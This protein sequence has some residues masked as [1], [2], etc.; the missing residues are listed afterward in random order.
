MPVEGQPGPGQEVGRWGLSWGRGCEHP[1]PGRHAPRGQESVSFSG[2]GSSAGLWGP[3]SLKGGLRGPSLRKD[4][5]VQTRSH[6]AWYEKQRQK[7]K[8]EGLP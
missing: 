1:R 2:R 6:R 7:M 5:V 8:G 3:R 4:L